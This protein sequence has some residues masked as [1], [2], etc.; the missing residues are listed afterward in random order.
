MEMHGK[1]S[2]K[3]SKERNY[4]NKN[5]IGNLKQK[6]GHYIE[7]DG[8]TTHTILSAWT[9]LCTRFSVVEKPMT[10]TNVTS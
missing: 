1:H 8:D 2:I 10:D 3:L 5:T 6:I 7:K 4:K 9:E